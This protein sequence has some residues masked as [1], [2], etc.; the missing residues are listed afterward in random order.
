MT[1]VLTHP[2]L[3]DQLITCSNSR[4]YCSGMCG[5]GEVPGKGDVGA[6]GKGLRGVAG[7]SWGFPVRQEKMVKHLV[8]PRS[9]HDSD[10]KAPGKNW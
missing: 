8:G 3:L 1:G 2:Q 9:E 4:R 5:T 7:R 10:G 6:T